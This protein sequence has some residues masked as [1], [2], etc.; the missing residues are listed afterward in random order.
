VRYLSGDPAAKNV[1]INPKPLG[2]LGE[3]VLQSALF[4]L[5]NRF[6][7]FGSLE[8]FAQLLLHMK[9]MLGLRSCFYDRRN[10][11]SAAVPKPSFPEDALPLISLTNNATVRR[12]AFGMNELQSNPLYLIPW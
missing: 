7:G 6:A 12:S 10:E 5:E 9:P 8:K 2:T 1:F 3:S 4:N 11:S